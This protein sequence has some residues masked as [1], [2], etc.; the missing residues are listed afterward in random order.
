MIRSA[1]YSHSKTPAA[2]ADAAW[3]VAIGND[4]A[5]GSGAMPGHV[6]GTIF[7]AAG[8]MTAHID[9]EDGEMRADEYGAVTRG[10]TCAALKRCLNL[11]P[12]HNGNINDTSNIGVQ[13]AKVL[14]AVP[15][16]PSSSP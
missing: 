8:Y 3:S 14:R 16:C 2:A 10:A 4:D 6:T 11:K 5:G 13:A 12:E 9:D 15:A 7:C 1:E